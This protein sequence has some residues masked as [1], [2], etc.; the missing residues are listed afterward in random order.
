MQLDCDVD[1]DL[2]GTNP[3]STEGEIQA[4][5]GLCRFNF[6]RARVLLGHISGKIYDELYSNRSRRL[7]AEARRQKVISLDR[8]LD[9]W[10]QSIPMPLRAEH[11]TQTLGKGPG[12]LMIALYRTYHFCLVVSRPHQSPSAI[13]RVPMF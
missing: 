4:L 11:L 13:K 10:H 1:L 5:D 6:F 7:T 12:S 9:Q 2:P 3:D 8:A